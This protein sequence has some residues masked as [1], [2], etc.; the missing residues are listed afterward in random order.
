MLLAKI[1]FQCR[2]REQIPLAG[3]FVVPSLFIYLTLRE[4]VRLSV[5]ERRIVWAFMY[6]YFF[7]LFS[8]RPTGVCYAKFLSLDPRGK[9]MPFKTDVSMKK[10]IKKRRIQE[11]REV[12]AL[13]S[14]KTPQV[15]CLASLIN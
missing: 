5:T 3:F 12:L 9:K 13:E 11:E 4:S 10:T 1:R 15:W 7:L 14:F 6:L 2:K 8:L